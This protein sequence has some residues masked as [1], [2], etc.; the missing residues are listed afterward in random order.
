MKSILDRASTG[1]EVIVTRGEEYF[2]VVKVNVK[3]DITPDLKE[4]LEAARAKYRAGD[5][6]KVLST[7]EDIDEYLESL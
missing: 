2:M 3:P 6:V 4:R 1:E 5:D 7:H